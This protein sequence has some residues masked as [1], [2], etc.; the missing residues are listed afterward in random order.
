MENQIADILLR[1]RNI[2]DAT[3]TMAHAGYIAIAGDAI[4]SVGTG[5]GSAYVG[6]KTQLIELGDRL[7]TPGLTDVHCFFN[8][9]L[10]QR[11]GADL[12]GVTTPEEALE[13]ISDTV[14][15]GVHIGHD[16]PLDLLP[17][18]REVLD[19][20]FSDEPAVFVGQWAE[21]M[22]LNTA[23]EKRFGFTPEACW[24]EKAYK[25]LHAIIGDES[26]SIPRWREYMSM[27][28]SYGVTS[29][30]EMSYDDCWIADGLKRLEDAGELTLRVNIMSQPVGAAANV[31]YVLAMRER[32][33]DDP[34]ITFS[35]FNQMTDGS[36][37]QHEGEMKAPYLDADTCCALDIDWAEHERQ[38][39]EADAAGLRFSLHTQ[40]DG[41]VAH[42]LDIFE[43]CQ[44][45]ASGRV[46]LAH[47]LTDLEAADPVD[48]ERLGKL[49]VIAE[50]YPLIQSVADRAGKIAMVNEKIGPER[51]THYW[52]RRKMIDSGV[53]VACGTDLPMTV[54]DLGTGVYC[55]CGGYFPEGGEPWNTQNMIEPGELIRAWCQG[56]ACD[57]EQQGVLG[58]LEAGKL[59]DIA[60]FDTNYLSIDPKEARG[61]TCVLTMVNGAIV[62]DTLN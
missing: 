13:R 27:M 55:A 58:T 22:A 49:G 15:G 24:S 30:K 43:K 12:S 40:G 14:V 16:F 25:L 19:A 42:A 57:L 53:T 54:D 45:D 48:L 34:F 59:A 21:G 38:V 29:A 8:G 7:V 9:W 11:A 60:V 26:F 31:P 4:M 17:V 28:N 52:N 47:A 46:K 33:A 32:F 51:G 6:P 2:F 50:V 23:A 36:I 56:G 61:G 35:G 44:R 3:D 5:D 18:S 20:V 1:S 37:S 41:A 39:L 10:L 62:H